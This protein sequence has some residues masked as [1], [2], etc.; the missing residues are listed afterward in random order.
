M[1]CTGDPR[2]R[3]ALGAV[4]L[5]G[6]FCHHAKA[7]RRQRSWRRLGAT[8]LGAVPR[9]RSALPSLGMSSLKIRGGEVFQVA[10]PIRRPHH[11]VG[12]T[13]R[14][15][16]GYVVLRLELENGIVRWGEAQ[17]IRDLGRRSWRPLW[18]TPKLT[19]TAIAEVLLPAIAG[20]NVT[21]IAQLHVRMEPCPAR[22]PYARGGHR[23][24]AISAR[25][26][27]SCSTGSTTR[28]GSRPRG[29]GTGGLPA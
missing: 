22:V 3:P 5:P 8:P 26:C 14:I 11:W 23:R 2:S 4:G 9:G 6:P 7:L 28:P 10:L 27:R 12:H 16:E 13:A 15:G 1:L 19:A 25:G 29:G 17:V 18:E 24:S 21:E 20:R